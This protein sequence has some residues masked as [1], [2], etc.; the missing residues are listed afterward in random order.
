[1]PSAQKRASNRK[2]GA[3]RDVIRTSLT[4]Q[5]AAHERWLR[6]AQGYEKD[7]HFVLAVGELEAKTWIE[8]RLVPAI[9]R[10]LELNGRPDLVLQVTSSST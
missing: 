3:L 6:S 4:D 7:G 10:A 2:E 5:N 1:M 9:Q 8:A